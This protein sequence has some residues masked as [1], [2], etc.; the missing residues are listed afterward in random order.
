MNADTSNA[1]LTDDEVCSAYSKLRSLTKEDFLMGGGSAEAYLIV[2]Q[3]NEQESG[4]PPEERERRAELALAEG[5]VEVFGRAAEWIGQS[6]VT[7]LTELW[8]KN[9]FAAAVYDMLVN[10]VSYRSCH[11]TRLATKVATEGDQ[12]FK[13]DELRL[14]SR[15]ELKKLDQVAIVLQNMILM[16]DCAPAA[17]G[18]Y[19]S[20]Q[21]YKTVRELYST[22][23]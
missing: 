9:G 13:A 7:S 23:K 5:L 14:N 4:L 17:I 11:S 21:M 16:C 19:R 22:C 2:K 1:Q 20:H 6:A 18:R 3:M 12:F 15:L 8:E 10:L